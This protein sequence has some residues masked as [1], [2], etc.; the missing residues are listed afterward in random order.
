M[1]TVNIINTVIN[2]SSKSYVWIMFGYCSHHVNCF[3]RR[4]WEKL[5]RNM[6]NVGVTSYCK[7]YYG[8]CELCEIILW[9]CISEMEY[10]T[11]FF[12]WI[13]CAWYGACR[14]TD[15]IICAVLGSVQK[16]SWKSLVVKLFWSTMDFAVG[17]LNQHILLVTVSS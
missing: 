14:D 3:R 17:F 4:D 7:Y 2:I 11:H 15:C 12:S 6:I 10:L 5:H 9:H 1:K 16:Y 8:I 13:G